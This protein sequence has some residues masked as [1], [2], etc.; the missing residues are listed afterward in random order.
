M[1]ISKQELRQSIREKKRFV[2]TNEIRR[3]SDLLCGM[4][5]QSEAYRNAGSLYGYIPFNQEVWLY[6]LLEQALTDGKTVALPKC[7]GKEMRF[8]IVSDLTQIQK[9]SRGIPEP[10]A[11]APVAT[12]PHSLVIVPGIAFDAA[13]Y[14]IGYGGGYYD[15]F[16]AQEP[17]HPT[18]GL[19]FDFQLV[20]QIPADPYDIP[21]D[22]VFWI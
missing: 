7:Y 20:E 9:N 12:D 8:I 1:S 6:P 22:T 4:V 5:L 15:R 16:F 17:H 14:R 10:A 21:A 2:S 13:G 11:D 18:I 19:C 3:R